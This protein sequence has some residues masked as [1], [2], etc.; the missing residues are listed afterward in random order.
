MRLENRTD[1]SPVGKL[2]GSAL[3]AKPCLL[4]RKAAQVDWG[5]D[6]SDESPHL[7]VNQGRSLSCERDSR[8]REI[9]VCNSKSK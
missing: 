3:F 4:V 6:S 7:E 1:N 9:S 8:E 2:R 5:F